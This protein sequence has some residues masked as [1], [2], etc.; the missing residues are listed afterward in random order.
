MSIHGFLATR[1]KLVHFCITLVFPCS[2]GRLHESRVLES[3]YCVLAPVVHY[4]IYGI[5]NIYNI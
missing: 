5:S 3:Y 1:T 4:N 2:G